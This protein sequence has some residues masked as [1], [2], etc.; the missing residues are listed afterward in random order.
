MVPIFS[1]F[2][3][4][5]LAIPDVRLNE[6]YDRSQFD[7]HA[8]VLSLPGHS[9]GSMGILTNNGD[10]LCGDLLENIRQAGCIPS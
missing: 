2:G 10:F 1:G 4:Q 6:G 8:S 3:K 5:S 7:V 9:K